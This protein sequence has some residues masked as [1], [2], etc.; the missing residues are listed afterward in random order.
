MIHCFR[1]ASVV[2]V[3]AIC[4]LSP[5]AFARSEMLLWEKSFDD[6]LFS[7]SSDFGDQLYF[8]FDFL[9]RRPGASTSI[10]AWI[11]TTPVSNA[12]MVAQT[13]VAEP[14]STGYTKLEWPQNL[15]LTD[16][17][18]LSVSG[19]RYHVAHL[20]LMP[21]TMATRFEFSLKRFERSDPFALPPGPPVFLYFVSY[22]FRMYGTIPEPATALTVT[23]GAALLTFG[24]TRRRRGSDRRF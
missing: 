2:A 1:M 8:S 18:Q 24:S 9:G 11:V 21:L 7:T 5:T 3:G 16:R 6:G 15:E 22:G 23:I 17:L 20:D 13:F 14:S 4:A 12:A 19:S 10:G